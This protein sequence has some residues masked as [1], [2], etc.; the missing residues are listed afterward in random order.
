MSTPGRA[1]RTHLR[2]IVLQNRLDSDY[3]D[4]AFAGAHVRARTELVGLR[5][6]ARHSTR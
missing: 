2:G 6:H 5:G 1:A 3:D 4:G